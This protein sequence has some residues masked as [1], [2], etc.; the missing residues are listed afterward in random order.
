MGYRSPIH[1]LELPEY[2]GETDDDS[3]VVKVVAPSIREGSDLNA[4]RRTNED[5]TEETSADYMRRAFTYLA[6]K[7]RFWN[8]EDGDGQPIP[9]PREVALDADPHVRSSRQV[10]H[11]Y[12][13]DENIILAIYHAWRMVSLPKKADTDEGKDSGPPSTPGPDASPLSERS[14]NLSEIDIRELEASIPM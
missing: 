3:L 9:L 10:D 14:G 5:G 4:G 12:E 6:P 13:Q 11:L 7:I 8:L 1:T 2:R